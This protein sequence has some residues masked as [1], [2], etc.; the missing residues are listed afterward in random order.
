MSEKSYVTLEQVLCTACGNPYESG[1]LL[2]DKRLRE[3]FERHT[4]TG[5]R[6]LCPACQKQVADGRVILVAVD[7][8]KSEQKPN[9]NIDPLK[10]HRTGPMAYIRREAF[11]RVFNAQPPSGGVAFVPDSVIETLSAI[12]TKESPP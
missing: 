4:V 10:A 9:G 5:M 8:A 6:G 12:A 3:R 1:N 11:E 2:L 7:L